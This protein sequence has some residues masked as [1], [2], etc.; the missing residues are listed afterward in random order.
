MHVDERDGLGDLA[1]RKG[2]GGS[3]AGLDREGLSLIRSLTD[4]V[5]ESS[6]RIN[7]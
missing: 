1:E 2:W 5:G 4:P 6:I 3:V 7:S